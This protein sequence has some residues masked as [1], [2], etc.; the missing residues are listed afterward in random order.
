MRTKK[1]RLEG[2][3]RNA[4]RAN[5]FIFSWFVP[6]VY[7]LFRAACFGERAAVRGASRTVAAE[8]CFNFRRHEAVHQA[9]QCGTASYSRG[10]WG[11]VNNR[12]SATSRRNKSATS[13]TQRDCHL[14]SQPHHHHHDPSSSFRNNINRHFS[15][16]QSTEWNKAHFSKRPHFTCAKRSSIFRNCARRSL[17]HRWVLRA[18]VK[19]RNSSTTS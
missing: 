17:N 7:L 12:L 6:R 3:F 18:L 14:N 4:G 5:T 2:A 19:S 1:V 9:E 11:N 8:T 16:R 15:Q 10:S 13:D